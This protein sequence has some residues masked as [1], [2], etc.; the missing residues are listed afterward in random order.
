VGAPRL[1]LDLVAER[2]LP[3]G[4][5]IDAEGN[6][7]LAEWGMGRVAVHASDGAFLRAVEV[8]APHS[9]CPVFGVPDLT[10]LYVTTA[11]EGMDAAALA[12]HPDA[13]KTFAAARAGRGRPEPKVIL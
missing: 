4:C 10:T 2:L 8:G 9:A 12:T 6:A 7:W 5:V 11:C 3:D 13:G 1:W